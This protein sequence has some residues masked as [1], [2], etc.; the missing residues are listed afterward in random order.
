MNCIICQAFPYLVSGAVQVVWLEETVQAAAAGHLRTGEKN[1]ADR[2]FEN[3]IE[4]A[5]QETKQ[6]RCHTQ[7][8]L[9]LQAWALPCHHCNTLPHRRSVGFSGLSKML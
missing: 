9:H 3:E 6:V 1:F 7:L 5:I 4:S 2:V 8:P